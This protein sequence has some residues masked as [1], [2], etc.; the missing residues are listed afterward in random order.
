VQPG[1]RRGAG[2]NGD[3]VDD[4]TIAD[5]CA[6]WLG[7]RPAA[8]IFRGGHLSVVAA[9]QLADGR[10]VVVKVRPDQARL[11]A[12]AYVHEYLW[13][14]GFPC[15]EPLV[16]TVPFGRRGALAASAETLLAGGDMLT[17]A[18]PGA[19]EAYAHLL[20]R[21]VHLA[22]PVD[23]VASIAPSPPWTA[24][25]HGGPGVWP[26]ADDRPDDLNVVPETAWLDDVG[27]AVQRRL[28]A[29]TTARTVVSHGDFEAHNL[30]WRGLEPMAVHDWDSV[31][32]APEPVAVGLAAAAWPAGAGPF[33][34]IEQTGSF[35]D[36][37]QRAAGRTWAVEEVEAAWASGLWLRAFNE[38]KWR[39][40]G[41]VALEPDEAAER[42]RRAGVGA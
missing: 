6:M 41:A 1:T 29:Q 7:S 4:R 40:D 37:Y 25:D 36:A 13:H 31:I 39:L 32:V 3:A 21:F 5:W 17:A 30:R 33:A 8:T 11:T 38:K 35:L 18:T 9:L 27:A 16:G 34:T 12:C 19:V 15:P 2:A 22:P 28:R 24:W 14:A 26:P 10:S 42:L 20:A 23:D